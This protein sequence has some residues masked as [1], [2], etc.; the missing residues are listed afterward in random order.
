LK[1]FELPALNP[2]FIKKQEYFMLFETSRFDAENFRTFIFIKPKKILKFYSHDNLREAFKIIEKHSRGFYLAG[3]FT[4]ELGYYFEKGIFNP[5]AS[6]PDPLIH[7]AVFDHGIVFNHRTGILSHSQ[8]DLFAPS[9]SIRTCQLKRIKLNLN[10]DEYTRAV[11]RIKHHI[12]AGDTYQVNF[13]GK[14]KFTISGEPYHLYCQLKRAQFVKYGAFSKMGS[15]HIISLSPELFFRKE[16]SQIIVRPMKGTMP[17]GK[18]VAE[19]NQFRNALQ[20]DKKNLAENI[21]IVD[22]LRNDLGRISQAGSIKPLKVFDIEKYCTLFQMTSTVRSTLRKNITCFELFQSLFPGG[23]VTGAPKIRTMQIIKEMEKEP[24]RVYCGALGFFAPPDK[25]I[26]NMPIRTIYIRDKKTEMGVGSGIVIDS[27]AGAEFS[28]CLLKTKF[29]TTPVPKFKLIETVLWNN[30]YVFGDEHLQ[31]LKNSAC[32]FDFKFNESEI[33][34]AL[35]KLSTS[36]M[37]QH[38]Y[39]VRLLL[40]EKGQIEIQTTSLAL[41]LSNSAPRIIGVS[42][43]KVDPRNVYYYHKTTNR[44]LYDS[45]YRNY[46]KK[47]C[48]EVVFLNTKGQL[49]EGAISNILIQ[50][51]TQLLTPPITCGLLPGIYRAFLLKQLKVKEKILYLKDFKAAD[52]IFICNSVRG[53]TEVT[54]KRNV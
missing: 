21:M 4:Y 37:P 48:F 36:F 2:G 6:F 40:T 7:L 45:E 24:R 17:R 41:G 39:R 38:C 14:Y 29:L 25:A 52:R 43:Y 31:R 16:G 53:I 47:G 15:E 23:S 35:K 26:F 46:Q 12:K 9:R 11:N 8:P 50:K 10:Q 13:T 28:E 20:Y 19:D 30:Q 42:K 54:L 5:P 33:R 34:I 1:Y 44:A 51:G 18:S 22:L 49:T 27:K 32:Y 3:Y